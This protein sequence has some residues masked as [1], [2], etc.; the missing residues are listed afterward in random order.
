VSAFGAPPVAATCITSG[1]L[2]D[3]NTI[4][5]SGPQ[6]APR[7]NPAGQ[8]VMAVPPAAGTFFNALSAKKPIHCPSGE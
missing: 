1:E 2:P 4:M 3:A 8:I 7:R 5:P 6:L